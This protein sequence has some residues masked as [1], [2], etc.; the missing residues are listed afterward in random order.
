MRIGET[1]YYSYSPVRQPEQKT[2]QQKQGGQNEPAASADGTA[3]FTTPQ[4]TVDISAGDS[5][6]L[7]KKSLQKRYKDAQGQMDEMR[8]QLESAKTQAKAA[9]ESAEVKMKCI[10]IAMRIMSGD[11]VPREDHRYLAKHDLELYCKAIT[12]RVAREKPRHYKRISEDEDD[13]SNNGCA[14]GSPDHSGGKIVDAD[15][16]PGI[17]ADTSSELSTSAVQSDVPQLETS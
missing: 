1:N 4:D 16:I 3:A 8:Q 10:T 7:Q 2:A 17:A 14:A 12:M 15:G 13:E 5:Q 6:Q 9:G 11:E